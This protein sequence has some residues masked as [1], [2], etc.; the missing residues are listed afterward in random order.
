M[1]TAPLTLVFV[2]RG[3]RYVY[4]WRRG[5]EGA[6]LAALARGAQ[7]RNHP[8]AWSDVLP[9]MVHMRGLVLG[10]RTPTP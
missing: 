9:V 7:D 5:N 2:V 1:T 4:H 3:H 6:L 8:L 10:G